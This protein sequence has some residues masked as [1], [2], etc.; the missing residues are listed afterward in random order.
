MDARVGAEAHAGDP[1]LQPIAEAAR[2]G[3]DDEI[4]VGHEKRT[5]V[6][7]CGD[8]TC[9]RERVHL[10]PQRNGELCNSAANRLWHYR[11]RRR[12]AQSGFTH[13][14]IR[15][16]RPFD[17]ARF[18]PPPRLPLASASPH[19]PCNAQ[20][21][22]GDDSSEWARDGE[23]DDPR[24]EGEGSAE[25]LVDADAFHDAT[26]CRT[27]LA[28]G[29]I[30]LRSERHRQPVCSAAGSKKATLR[31]RPAS[32]PTGYTFTGS[33]GQRAVVD[34]RSGD[35]DPYILVR[36]PSGE[37]FDNDDFEGDA[38][39]S[40]LVARLDRERRIPRSPSRATARARPAVTRCRST[41]AAIPA[42]RHAWNATASSSRATTR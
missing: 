1:R 33:N 36:A 41:S 13:E 39:R 4:A 35:F 7:R 25:T 12:R 21:D 28:P 23:C 32:T 30:S 3:R 26:D 17:T 34:L 14:V 27:L 10:G 40:L 29:R 11:G 38:S 2:F 37:Q 42:S 18:Q 31:S 24:F 9:R 6:G 5:D 22:F 16:D 15:H 19:R 8:L 20:P